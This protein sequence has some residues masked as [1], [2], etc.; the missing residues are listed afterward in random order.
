MAALD[1]LATELN[2]THLEQVTKYPTWVF[3]VLKILNAAGAGKHVATKC[4]AAIVQGS[5]DVAVK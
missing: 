4:T 3:E 1:A 2:R 5:R